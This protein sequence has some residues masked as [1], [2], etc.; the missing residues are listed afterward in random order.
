MI[1]SSEPAI[2]YFGTPVAL[3]SSL[4]ADGSA[5]LAPMSSVF[6]LGWR[7]VLGLSAASQ[8]AQNLLR[9]PELVINLP[10]ADMADRVDRLALTTAANPVPPY[11]AQ[12]GYGHVHAKFARAGL[13]PVASETVVPP[14]ALE[15]PV[16]LEARIEAVHSIAAEDAALAGRILTFEAR[17][18]RVHVD[19]A[20]LLAGDPNRIDPDKWRP[21]IMSFQKFYGL[22][23]QVRP[24]TLATIAEAEYR[25]PDVDKARLAGPADRLRIAA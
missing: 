19:E 21:L 1:R 17:I 14:R 22:G 8:T 23:E 18:L 25:S 3:L 6:W 13:T 15:A 20:I 11:K 4:N 10:S 5:N 16:Q 12:R 2:L 7:A 9:H 24:S